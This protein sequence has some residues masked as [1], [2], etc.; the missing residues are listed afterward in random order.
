[1]SIVIYAGSGQFLAVTLIASQTS[2]PQVALLT[3]LLNFRHFFYGLSMISRYKDAGAR[4]GYLI[5]AMTDETYALSPGRYRPGGRHGLLLRRLPAG[6][7]LLDRRQPDRRS[8]RQPHH[9]RH[10]RRG[11][12]HDRSVRGA[13]R[14]AV[15]EQFPA[16]PALFGLCFGIASLLIFGAD[17]FL[18]PALVAI[19]AA[20]LLARRRLEGSAGASE[21]TKKEREVT[22]P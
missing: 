19:A 16:R 14:G 18:I 10:H 2:L 12:R 7:P 13:G 1:M 22:P 17:L 6:S 9:L 21:G 11:L 20:L 15:E 4:K 3:F 5:F 8:R